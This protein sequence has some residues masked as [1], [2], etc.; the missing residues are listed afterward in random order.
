MSELHCSI[1]YGRM[2]HALN[3][4]TGDDRGSD[5]QTEA[6]MKAADDPPPGMIT[7]PY[8]G[9]AAVFG[10]FACGGISGTFI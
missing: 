4:S 1:G 8:V 3:S 6:K 10:E 9:A 7:L 5:A 2:E